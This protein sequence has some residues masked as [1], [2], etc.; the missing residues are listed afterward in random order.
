MGGELRKRSTSGMRE[1]AV[2]SSHLR[3]TLGIGILA[4]LAIGG[5]SFAQ[6]IAPTNSLP[7]P[8][9]SIENWG[10]LPAG[11]AWGL[12]Q[13]GRHRSRWH[14][15]LGRRTLRRIPAAVAHR[16]RPA[17]RVRRLDPRPDPQIRSVRQTAEELRRRPV[18]V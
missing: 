13:R 17:V 16:S 18:V 6:T 11:Q 5:L 2:M 10:T 4:I 14:E 8:Y 15:R 1:N 7:N 9:R 3:H 12:D